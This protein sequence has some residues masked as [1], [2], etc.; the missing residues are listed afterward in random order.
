[1]HMCINTGSGWIRNTHV[2]YISVSIL[3][4]DSP[5]TSSPGTFL[6]N[7]ENKLLQMKHYSCLEVSV[8]FFLKARQPLSVET[9]PWPCTITLLKNC[10]G[11]PNILMT[12]LSAVGN[13]EM[14]F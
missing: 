8:P 5:N 10:T 1:M 2:L 7:S 12:F 9:A 4:F 6:L 14:L 11:L 13:G 3:S